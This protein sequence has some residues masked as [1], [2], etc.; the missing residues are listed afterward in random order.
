[1]YVNYHSSTSYNLRLLASIFLLNFKAF[2]KTYLF[3]SSSFS[4][5][6][7]SSYSSISL[8]LPIASTLT[9][10]LK[11]LTNVANDSKP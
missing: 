8:K 10:V 5:V 3:F 6:S 2:K 4:F 11:Y 7:L 1:M 9:I